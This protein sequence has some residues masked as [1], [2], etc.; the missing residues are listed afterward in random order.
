MMNEIERQ[1]L[2]AENDGYRND[3]Q[4]AMAVSQMRQEPSNGQAVAERFANEGLYAVVV[5]VPVYCKITDALLRNDI[6][7]LG[8][9]ESLRAAE[10]RCNACDPEERP[11]IVSPPSDPD[12]RD[13]NAAADDEDVPF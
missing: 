9:F 13:V 11:R 2:E 5:E 4:R 3:Y 6:R 10:I 1:E 8:A 7:C 12:P